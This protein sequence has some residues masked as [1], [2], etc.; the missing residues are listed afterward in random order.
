VFC[1]D[2]RVKDMIR[3][4]VFSFLFGFGI[5]SYYKSGMFYYLLLCFP[6]L[7]F[8]WKI[9]NRWNTDRK[10]IKEFKKD[11]PEKNKKLK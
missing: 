4:F 6:F 1:L 9:G 8:G 7:L 10:K 2:D 11:F 3:F 5:T